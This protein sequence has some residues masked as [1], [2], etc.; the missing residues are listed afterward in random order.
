M[1]TTKGEGLKL[2][3]DIDQI[4]ERMIDSGV[5]IHAWTKAN[6]LVHYTHEC[7]GNILEAT[8]V[9]CQRAS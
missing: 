9:S 6:V 8:G 4:F 5:K 7:L 3:R 2:P 1:K